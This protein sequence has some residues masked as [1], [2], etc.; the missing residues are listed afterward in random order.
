MDPRPPVEYSDLLAETIFEYLSEGISMKMICA[1]PGMP[2]YSTARRW[3]RTRKDY[4]E[5]AMMARTVGYHYLADECLE[6]A[7]DATNDYIDTNR[8]PQF[9]S[10]HVRR[11]QLRIDTRMRLLE[12]WAPMLY[13]QKIDHSHSGTVKVEKIKY[14]IIDPAPKPVAP[15]AGR[16]DV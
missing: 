11:S 4:A 13:G 3:E 8:G 9:D 14:V 6:I 15:D 12:K 16:T 2:S 7:D 10:E 1:K 5:K